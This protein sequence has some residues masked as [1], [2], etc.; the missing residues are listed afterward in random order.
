MTDLYC[1]YC[2]YDDETGAYNASCLQSDYNDPLTATRG[3]CNTTH[4]HG[5]LAWAYDYCPTPFAWMPMM[6]LVVYLLFFAP[7]EHF[8]ERD[9]NF[10]SA[11]VPA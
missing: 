1:G 8:I 11:G 10:R 9:F 4:L 7:G 6:G 3:R 2:Y 5:G